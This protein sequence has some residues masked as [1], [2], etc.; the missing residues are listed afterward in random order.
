MKIPSAASTRR[1]GA[2]L[3]AVSLLA[4][5]AG[6]C[7]RDEP[8]PPPPPGAPGPHHG[9]RPDGPGRDPAFDAAMQD[10]LQA[11]GVQKPQDDSPGRGG[12]SRPDR[13]ALDACLREK[14]VQPPH[15]GP[16]PHDPAIDAAFQAC[17]AT[18]GLGDEA[19]PP[20]PAQRQQMDACL[21]DKGVNPPP[22]PAEAP[23]PPTR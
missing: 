16:H 5:C 17:K 6:M 14:G 7:P 13:E 23:P 18:L 22:H 12:P 2:L 11:L 9:H 1:V 20:P 3:L 21:K 10:C 4:G 15:G 8:P 19:G